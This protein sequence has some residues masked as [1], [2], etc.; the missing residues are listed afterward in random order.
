MKHIKLF[1]A[2]GDSNEKFKVTINLDSEN[3]DAAYGCEVEGIGDTL[4]E[5]AR[6]AFAQVCKFIVSGDDLESLKDLS[7]FE[8]VTENI[9]SKAEVEEAISSI[10]QG[11]GLESNFF[12]DH[13]TSS[14]NTIEVETGMF[15]ENGGFIID[16]YSYNKY[17]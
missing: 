8:D 14:R 9:Y 7:D 4:D 13:G 12:S 10:V 16:Q 17:D 1:E 6:F 2:F 3:P 5:A 15:P 11:K